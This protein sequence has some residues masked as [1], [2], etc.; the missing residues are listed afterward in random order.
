MDQEI[1][2]IISEEDYYNIKGVLERFTKIDANSDGLLS[3]EQFEFYL[4]RFAL[5]E[6]S[7][8]KLLNR[9]AD[10]TGFVSLT[11]FSLQLNYFASLNKKL[12]IKGFKSFTKDKLE[13]LIDQVNHFIKLVFLSSDISKL[14]D[15]NSD[16]IVHGYFN[17]L[18]SLAKLNEL[19][20]LIKT[21][22]TSINSICEFLTFLSNYCLNKITSLALDRLMPSQEDSIDFIFP[23][24]EKISLAPL[25]LNII[26]S[27]QLIDSYDFSGRTILISLHNVSLLSFRT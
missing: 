21:L 15:D 2:R 20:V 23:D 5:E 22:N 3:K 24:L 8:E 13:L 12:E 4:Q 7:K 27:K 6:T 16:M 11:N 17:G 1:I 19:S 25:S 26:S 14:I 18:I 9:F 10:E